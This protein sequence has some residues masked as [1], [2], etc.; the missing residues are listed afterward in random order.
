MEAL[1]DIVMDELDIETQTQL[2][3]LGKR[4]RHNSDPLQRFSISDSDNANPN[5]KLDPVVIAHHV[6]ECVSKKIDPLLAHVKDQIDQ[7][8][9]QQAETMATANDVVRQMADAM[10]RFNSDQHILFEQFQTEKVPTQHKEMELGQRFERQNSQ[11]NQHTSASERL[12][13][14]LQE[15][16]AMIANRELALR[17]L[18]LQQ[19]ETQIAI[20]RQER[21]FSNSQQQ[22]APMD[23]VPTQPLFDP[24]P[25]TNTA[26]L[27]DS[28]SMPRVI[29]GKKPIDF[30]H[31]LPATPY[32]ND[33]SCSTNPYSQDPNEQKFARDSREKFVGD[34]RQKKIDSIIYQPRISDGVQD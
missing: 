29:D 12:L 19:Q 18:H 10:T 33:I 26:P 22:P 28:S 25:L 5:T 27:M 6:N 2:I 21:D 14:G 17:Q 15:T 24:E 7:L 16:E 23:D 31:S 4:P 32:R 13:N 8:N 9:T 1:K 11:R 20:L 30:R 34:R 3:A